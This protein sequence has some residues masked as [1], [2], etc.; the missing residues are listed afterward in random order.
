[1]RFLIE[2][3]MKLFQDILHFLFGNS[4]KRIEHDWQLKKSQLDKERIGRKQEQELK[5][6]DDDIGALWDQRYQSDMTQ[7]EVL[8]EWDKKH[9]DVREG[10]FNEIGYI[11]NDI[12]YH[13]KMISEHKGFFRKIKEWISKLTSIFR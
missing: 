2:E 1:M 4:K 9:G 13:E 6:L 8:N 10:Q 11:E 5:A 7:S 12:E 3:F